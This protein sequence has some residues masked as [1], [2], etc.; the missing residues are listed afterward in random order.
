[1]LGFVLPRPFLDGQSYRAVRR[2][3]AERFAA[4]DLVALPDKVFRH[5]EVE[6]VLLM[7]HSPV[8][9]D[10]TRVHFS[11]VFKPQLRGFL[12]NGAVSRADN[13][14]FTPADAASKG[15]HVPTLHE[16]WDRL[17]HLPKLGS[18]AE[19]H[20]GVEWQA[21]FNEAKYISKKERPGWLRGLRNVREG[22]QAFSLPKPSWL[23]PDPRFRRGNAWDLSWQS[24]KV[25]ANAATKARGAW[26]L[27]A[28]PD[29]SGLVC[30]QRY[31][32]I[33]PKSN[34][35]VQSLA[36]L[37]NSPVVS[38]FVA[39]REGKRDVRKATLEDC[40]IP[41]LPPSA[42]IELEGLVDE[43][44]TAMNEQPEARLPLW[45]GGT[46]E[47]RAKQILLQMDALILK[48]YGLPPWLERK[49]LDFFRGQRRPVPFDFGDYFPADFAPNIPLWRY[50]SPSF[51]ASRPQ[52]IIPHLPELRDEE[53]TAALEELA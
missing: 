38:A 36:A 23:N 52:Y 32:C 16:I 33:W 29:T 6:T 25:V 24:P 41:T 47:Q 51:Q 12:S 37:L 14:T 34:W 3:I 45:G 35:S 43:Y 26:R 18:V 13:A 22:F 44:L 17:A 10:R 50:I 31:H 40:P 46:W 9:H 7:A 2:Q 42:I 1:M 19:I 20:R 15:F 30:T 48:G 39:S 11:E 27:A 28:A 5:A 4:V 8:E 53:L 21:P 49:L